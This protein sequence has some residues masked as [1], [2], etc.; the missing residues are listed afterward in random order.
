MSDKKGNRHQ[1]SA[2]P[3]A[4]HY[5]SPAAHYAAQTQYAAM[6]NQA[7][8]AQQVFPA[9]P[10]TYEQAMGQPGVN[11][12]AQANNAWIYPQMYGYQT[13]AIQMPGGGYAAYTPAGYIQ[14]PAYQATAAAQNIAA[15]QQRPALLIP[16]GNF[17]GG[18]RFDGISQRVVPPAPPGVAPNAAQLAA[19]SGQTV[20]L[21][22][23]KGNFLTGS[24]DGGFTF[25]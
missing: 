22:Q 19:M 16:G 3:P 2:P 24:S 13:T 14:Y 6:Y 17:D 25:W 8:Q 1:P 23:K 18:A 15:T 12:A 21:G 7:M 5:I 4:Q 20:I 10:P 9:P 11:P